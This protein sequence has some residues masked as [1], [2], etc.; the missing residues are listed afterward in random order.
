MVSRSSD[1][2]PVYHAGCTECEPNFAFVADTLTVFPVGP[3]PDVT[4]DRVQYAIVNFNMYPRRGPPPGTFY[5]EEDR[6]GVRTH[7]TTRTCTLSP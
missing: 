7:K 3:N 6:L 2:E 5:P 1:A 4:I